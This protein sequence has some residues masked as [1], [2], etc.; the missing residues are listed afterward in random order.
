[1][2]YI[3]NHKGVYLSGGQPYLSKLEAC[4]AL[5]QIPGNHHVH[6]DY[7]ENVYDQQPWTVEPPINI[8]ELYKQRALQ[9]REE[10][11][12]LVLFYSG[13]ADSHTVL[14]SFIKNNIKIDEVFCF[15]AFKAED[16]VNQ[17]LGW[18]RNPGY[19]TRE[20]S[21]IV[22]PTLEKL[23]KIH[24]F[25]I[26][27]WDWTDHI[28]D[29]LSTKEDWFVD[30]GTRFAPDAIARRQL[31]EA[32]RHN[33]RFEGRGKKVAFIY[34]VDKPRLFRD[35]KQVYVAFIDTLLTTGVG[36][37][38]DIH[39]RSWENDEY[40]YWTPNL[41]QIVIKQAHM[42]YNHLKKTNSISTLA[43]KDLSAP[44]HLTE[45]YQMIHPI[46]YP[47]WNTNTWQIKKP[48]GTVIDEFSQWFF[49]LA[50]AESQ[51]RWKSG[52][53]EV[54]RQLGKRW[55]NNGNIYDGMIGN[56]SKFYAIGPV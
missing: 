44:M 14:Q 29:T 2:T 11:D 33:D 45:Y 4:L 25:K 39:H 10:Y 17:K 30:V 21:S 24:K 5:N 49:D 54:E 53:N 35:D 13:G 46:I 23:Q 3:Y 40:F 26:T 36:N 50:P 38:A 19:Y 6:W 55:F 15:G 32:F 12:H 37:T 7:H 1:M 9:L 43:H 41:P 28:L 34:G 51:Q 27:F 52:V 22:K 47:S 16:R 56:Y 31:H 20:V 8:E 48:T 42:I 18:D